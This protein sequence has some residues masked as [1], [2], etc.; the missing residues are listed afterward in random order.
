M[1]DPLTDLPAVRPRLLFFSRR[2]PRQLT[3]PQ[4][5]RSSYQI[6]NPRLLRYALHKS[7]PSRVSPPPNMTEAEMK[8]V[9]NNGFHGI[10]IP[11][12]TP[13]LMKV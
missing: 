8:I 6:M 12:N 5:W 11:A 7:F 1:T 2:R 9:E 13:N 10:E 4:Y 3:R